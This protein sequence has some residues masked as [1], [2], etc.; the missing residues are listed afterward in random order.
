MLLLP[1]AKYCIVTRIITQICSGLHGV[2]GQVITPFKFLQ[3]SYCE[4]R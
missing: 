1:K 2:Q 3:I 4:A